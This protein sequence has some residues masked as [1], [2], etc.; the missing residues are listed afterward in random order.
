MA[1]RPIIDPDLCGVCGDCVKAC[2]EKALSVN[3]EGTLILVD[4]AK[5]N[6]AGKCE[7]VCPNDAIDLVPG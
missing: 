7:E 1:E 3:T 4:R 5:C 2:P 6:G